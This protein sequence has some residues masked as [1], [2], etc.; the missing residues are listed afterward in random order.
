MWAHEGHRKDPGRQAAR[1]GR[2]AEGNG[3]PMRSRRRQTN[4]KTCSNGGDHPVPLDAGSSLKV[5]GARPHH[6]DHCCQAAHPDRGDDGALSR[7]A[8]SAEHDPIGALAAAAIISEIG[9]SP[10][11]FFPDAAHL[12]SWT[13][14]CPGNHES[15]GRRRHGNPHLQPVLVEAAWAAVRH[16]GYLKALY[17][18]HVM[19]WD[20]CRSP[21]AKKK[22]LIVVHVAGLPCQGRALSRPAERPGG[23]AA[24]PVGCGSASSDPARPQPAG[25]ALTHRSRS[26]GG[27]GTGCGRRIPRAG[28]RS[29]VSPR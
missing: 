23:L 10:A 22:A 5:S 16:N 12:A 7:R 19:R 17:H 13:G 28:A 20:G 8:G 27:A 21:T 26:A 14:I 2:A 29:S 24:Q 9:A 1:S 6:G 15:A 3:K 18:R 4:G 25:A 11:E